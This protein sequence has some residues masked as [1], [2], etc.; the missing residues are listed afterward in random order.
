MLAPLA[1]DTSADVEARQIAA[2]REMSP[3]EKVALVAALTTTTQELAL[4]G[5]R[6]RYPDRSPREHFLRLAIVNLGLDLA[7]KAYPEI[8]VLDHP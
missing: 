1:H 3:A 2:W 8:A 5:V 4:A 6:V 7:R